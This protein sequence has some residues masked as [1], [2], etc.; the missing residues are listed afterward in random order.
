MS[1]SSQPVSV[2]MPPRSRAKKAAEGPRVVYLNAPVQLAQLL[3]REDA[4]WR[5]RMGARERVVPA[6]AAVDPALLEEAAARH[7]RVVVDASDPEQPVIAGLLATC[8]TLTI[9]P[10]GRVEASVR[11]LHLAATEEILLKTRSAFVRLKEAEIETFAQRIVSR[12]RSTLRFLAA[13]IQHN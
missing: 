7:A 2:S 6:D 3:G 13:Q 1:S 9:Q 8:R 5:V 10:D 11:A 4:G 12:A